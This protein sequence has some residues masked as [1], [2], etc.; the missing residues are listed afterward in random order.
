MIIAPYCIGAPEEHKKTA[1]GIPTAVDRQRNTS[2]P[3]YFTGCHQNE[4]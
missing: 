1:T 3:V 2:N 4:K